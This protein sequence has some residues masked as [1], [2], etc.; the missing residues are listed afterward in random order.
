MKFRE[1][2][3]YCI[4]WAAY[5]GRELMIQL[6]IEHGIDTSKKN[7]FGHTAADEAKIHLLKN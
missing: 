2:F 5:Y 6:L 1:K 3:K 7:E 4:T